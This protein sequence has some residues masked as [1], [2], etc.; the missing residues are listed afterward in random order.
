VPAGE[1]VQPERQVRH[2]PLAHPGGAVHH[3]CGHGCEYLLHSLPLHRGPTMQRAPALSLSVCVTSLPGV[4]E[5]ALIV[6]APG[7]M[8]AA[9]VIAAMF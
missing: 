7:M 2:A 4:K 5:I 8:T 6:A 3:A 9:A 1:L